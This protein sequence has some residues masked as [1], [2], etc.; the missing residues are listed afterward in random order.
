FAMVQVLRYCTQAYRTMGPSV[1]VGNI[2]QPAARFVA[3][4]ALLIAGFAVTGAVVSLIVAAGIAAIAGLYYLN[5][6]LSEEERAAPVKKET[7]QMV[8]F[9]LLQMAASLL[10]IQTLGLGILLLSAFSTNTQVGLFAIALALQGPGNVFLGGIVNIWAPVVTD[11]YERKEIDRLESLYQTVN[12]WVATFSFPIFVALM[13]TPEIFVRL[14]AGSAGHGAA[15]VV[16]LLAIGNIFYVGTGPTG[17]VLSMTGRP[18]INAI[19]SAVSVAIYISLGIA[20]TQHHGAVG[21]AI[22]DSSVTA[23]VN[24]IRVVEAYFLVGVQPFGRRFLKPVVA[25]AAVAA[26]LLAG[27]IALGTS[28]PVQGASLLVGLGAYVLILKS[29]G[30]D[31]EERHVL[32]RIRRRAFRRGKS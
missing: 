22:I 19:N 24:S 3:G 21:M 7:G 18:G 30:L 10:G 17:Y 20:V 13:V 31:E 14:F 9:S 25:S 29:L 23:L 5:R 16:M 6:M 26:I 2:I 11:L 28:A 12:R 15:E 8:R 32:E 4:V 27:R 1:M